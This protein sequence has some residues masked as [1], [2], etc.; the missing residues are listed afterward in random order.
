LFV[1]G[2]YLTSVSRSKHEYVKLAPGRYAYTAKSKSTG[3]EMKESFV[4]NSNGLNE[5]FIDMMYFVDE[6]NHKRESIRRRAETKV[7]ENTTQQ[8]RPPAG[9]SVAEP[10]KTAITALINN[11]VAVKGGSFVMGNNKAPASDEVEHPV[12]LS[13][14][15]FGKYEVTQQQWESLMGYNPSV[16]KN[17]NDCPVENVS[18]EE[19]M[20]FIAKLNVLSG[21]KFRL[22]TEA[23]WEYVARIGG[24]EEIENEGGPEQYIKKTAWY[25]GNSEKKTHPVGEL[26]ANAA[27]VHDLLGN[28]SEWCSDWY[29][30]Y[31]YKEENNHINPEGPPLGKE[32]VV[33]GGSYLD[34]SGDRF[35][36]SLREKLR[37]TAKSGSIGFRLV[38]E[39]EAVA[40]NF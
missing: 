11:M 38:L 22:P 20:R 14:V 16:N 1:A 28:V 25:Y 7:A 9:P 40:S 3:D 27:G 2:E 33:R 8:N 31:Y 15:K 13:A 26:Q 35:R 36:P 17:C 19:A 6:Q 24:R 37:P 23:E 18:W 34:Y 21:R 39:S 29:G 12:T 4:V 5:V 32:K 30:P 10:V